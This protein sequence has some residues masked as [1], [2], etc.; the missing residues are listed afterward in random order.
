M[1]FDPPTPAEALEDLLDRERAM[2][3]NGE[4]DGLARS[5]P[6]KEAL[7]ASLKVSDAAR[8]QQLRRKADRNQTLLQAVARGL[9]AARDRIG[10]SGGTGPALRTYGADGAAHDLGLRFR[11]PGVNHRA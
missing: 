1:R 2:I 8:L 9:K 5:A 7:I 3:L 6:R 4:L 11:K 10:R